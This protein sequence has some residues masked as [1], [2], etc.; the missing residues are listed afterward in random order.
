MTLRSSCDFPDR[1]FLKHKFKIAEDWCVFKFLRPSLHGK[2]L[3]RFQGE[4]FVFKFLRRS[5]E[6]TL[7]DFNGNLEWNN[8]AETKCS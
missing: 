5:V 3:K 8:F 6:G 4:T 7:N 2:H 1:V